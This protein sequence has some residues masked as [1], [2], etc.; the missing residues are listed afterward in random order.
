[1]DTRFLVVGAGIA[2]ASAAYELAQAVGGEHV[3]LVER[4]DHPGYHATGRSAALYTET[5]GGPESRTTIS[6]LARASRPFLERTPAGF[7][8][9]PILTPRGLVMLARADQH[10]AAEAWFAECRNLCTDLTL[11]DGDRAESLIPVLRPGHFESAVFEPGAMDIDVDALHQGYLKGFRAAGG[12]I[13]MRT[14][15]SRLERRDGR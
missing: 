12:T 4:E 1:M 2:G 9:H 11:I 7:T 10:T 14:K 6:A 8:D 3:V 13:A 15:V 5:Y